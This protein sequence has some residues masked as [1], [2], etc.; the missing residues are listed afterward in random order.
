MCAGV[1]LHGSYIAP[2]YL[3]TPNT[4][5]IATILGDRD[6]LVHLSHI[7]THR[8]DAV[9]PVIP[10]PSSRAMRMP[11]VILP[12][13]THAS[14]AAGATTFYVRPRDLAPTLPLTAATASIAS[15]TAGFILMTTCSHPPTMPFTAHPS[16]Y[17]S[18]PA[19]CHAANRA[20]AARKA[21]DFFLERLMHD[22]AHYLDPFTSALQRDLDGVTCVTAQHAVLTTPAAPSHADAICTL[23]TPAGGTSSSRRTRISV[24]E[25][26][27]MHEEHVP[28]RRLPPPF[29]RQRRYD[30]L[31]NLAPSAYQADHNTSPAQDAVE[32]CQAIAEDATVSVVVRPCAALLLRR[33]RGFRLSVPASPLRLSCKLFTANG[34]RLAVARSAAAT[35]GATC[36]A[37][38][39][40]HPLS[41]VHPCPVDSA[42][43]AAAG[44]DKMHALHSLNAAA[45]PRPPVPVTA[46]ASPSPSKGQMTAARSTPEHSSTP[47]NAAPG[48]SPGLDSF[49]CARANAAV[50]TRVLQKLPRH[51]CELYRSS[52]LRLCF[53]VDIDIHSAAAWAGADQDVVFESVSAGCMAPCAVLPAHLTGA[54]TEPCVEITPDSARMHDDGAISA[55]GMRYAVVNGSMHDLG[56]G[57]LCVHGQAAHPV[58][59][60]LSMLGKRQSEWR[61]GGEEPRKGGQQPSSNGC[62]CGYGEPMCAGVIL[63]SPRYVAAEEGVLCCVVLSEAH[64]FEYILYG[65]QRGL[66]AGETV[67]GDDGRGPVLARAAACCVPDD[68]PLFDTAAATASIDAAAVE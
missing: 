62:G 1:I 46:A 41:D 53:G 21:A 10:D 3:D 55:T 7:A 23:T 45:S 67:A 12:G 52:P 29:R 56:Q 11:L 66:G 9:D 58:L 8:R 26:E 57:E 36:S 50:V 25:P 37:P 24:R 68:V 27:M 18:A 32:K 35:P 20:A 2:A 54:G 49:A 33:P 51:V 48:E 17:V 44:A 64:A 43:S 16:T 42:E 31:A 40:S 39:H 59:G 22:T 47:S 4:A 28:V 60:T 19:T 34:V 63:R 30:S 14:F 38:C 6:G 5:P 15:A 61:I 65:S 13:V